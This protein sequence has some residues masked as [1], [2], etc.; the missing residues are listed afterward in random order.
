MPFCVE[1]PGI[2]ARPRCSKIIRI[3]SEDVDEQKKAI[4][5]LTS[6]IKALKAINHPAVLKLLHSN[7]ERRFIVTAISQ[8]GPLS[9]RHNLH[10]F[11][12]NSLAALKAFSNLLSG[13]EAIHKQGAIHRDIKTDN[14]FLADSGDLVLGDFGIVFFR[15]GDR[16]TA[17]LSV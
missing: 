2:A 14:I 10:L 17:R 5:R 12:G 15:E 7:L 3:S 11:K 6:E 9:K 16:W 8:H 4:A 13:V 1:P